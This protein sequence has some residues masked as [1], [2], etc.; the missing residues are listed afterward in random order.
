MNVKDFIFEWRNQPVRIRLVKDCE[1]LEI[2]D[3]EKLGPYKKGDEVKLPYWEAKILVKQNYA[4]FLDFK[5]IQPADL[6]KILYRELPKSQLTPIDPYFYVKIHETLLELT[7][8]NKKNPDLL[9]LQKIKKM[10][11]LLRDVLS[12]RFYKLLRMAAATG[13]V[14]SEML[15]NC[16]NEERELYESLRK[17]L[18]EW[19]A[20]FLV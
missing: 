10:K 13:K 8:Q 9:V 4:Q 5:P 12:R 7:E 19:E 14:S 6:H 16:S 1:I 18:T 15:E 3:D 17:I 11:S 2:S 20:Q